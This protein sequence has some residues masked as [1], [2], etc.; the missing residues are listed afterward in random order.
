LALLATKRPV[1]LVVEDEP[2][3]RLVAIE[4]IEEAGYEV[5]EAA[6]ADKTIAILEL[7]PDVHTVFS[8]IQMPGSMDSLRLVAYVRNRWPPVK[9]V[10][11]SGQIAVAARDLP[12]GAVFIGK[13]STSAEISAVLLDL[14]R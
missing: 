5:L 14:M 6:D 2:L 11:T 4:M 1:V 10:T 8:E 13:P 3:L 9:L 7:R 12:E